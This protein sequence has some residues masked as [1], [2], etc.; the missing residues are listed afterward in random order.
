VGAS[1]LLLSPGG[2]ARSGVFTSWHSLSLVEKIDEQMFNR[3][4]EAMQTYWLAYLLII[5]LAICIS[6]FGIVSKKNVT[7][8]A[9]FFVAAIMANMA[10]IGAPFMPPRAY[11]GALCFMLISASFLVHVVAREASNWQKA[12]VLTVVFTFGLIYFIPSYIMFT[13][14]VERTWKQETVRQLMIKQQLKENS[15]DISIPDH[16]FTRILKKTDGYPDY[17]QPM[18]KDV[19]KVNS[20]TEFPA[21]FDYST[22][23]QMPSKDAGFYLAGGSILQKIYF[24]KESLAGKKFIIYKINDDFNKVLSQ[25]MAMFVHAKM[26]GKDGYINIDTSNPAINIMGSWYTYSDLAGKDVDFKEIESLNIG[27]YQI[28]PLQNPLRVLS[29][30]TVT[31]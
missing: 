17:K 23:D 9:I 10:F 28:T 22:L 4:P 20:F 3:M 7:Y 15:K 19:Y 31:F 27:V 16:Y 18:V 6:V 2:A 24:Y 25:G 30:N 1:V 26:K 8:A 29:N 5:V 13:N 14:A 21:F 12:S 11:N